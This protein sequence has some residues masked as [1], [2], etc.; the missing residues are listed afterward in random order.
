MDDIE[1]ICKLMGDRS[2]KVETCKQKVFPTVFMH[3][4][5]FSKPVSMP[6]TQR[7]GC[8]LS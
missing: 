1:D 4:L 8:M 5:S 7:F 2:V 3:C 6:K